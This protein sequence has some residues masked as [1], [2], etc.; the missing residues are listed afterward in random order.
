MDLVDAMNG[1]G[2]RTLEALKRRLEPVIA[3]MQK[4]L[5][6]VDVPR[7]P[8]ES[9]ERY[10]RRR[11][12]RFYVVAVAFHVCLV[13]PSI[14][15]IRGCN[16]HETPLGVPGGKGDKLTAGKPI[17]IQMQKKV[18]QRKRKVRKSPI[19]IYEMIQEEDLQTVAQT[20]AQFSD[21]AGVP[22]G[23]GSGACAAGSP[24][25]TVVGGT[26]Y[27]YR[28]KFGGPD[29]DA[30]SEG[31]KPLMNEVLKAGVVKKVAGYNNVVT[32]AELPKHSGQYFPAMLY[33]T[34]TGGISASDQEVSNLRD[35][36][37]NGGML[38][39]DVSGGSF[40]ENFTQFIRR[41][42]PNQKI[43]VIEFDNEIYRGA[44]MPYAL[45]HGCPIY[46]KHPG[47]GP[48]MGIWIGQRLSVFYS[49][50]DLGAGWAS[51]GIFQTRRRDVEQAYRMGI[52]II[53]YSLFYYKCTTS[54]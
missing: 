51:A 36:L 33:M 30:N 13:L 3:F 43:S 48:A 17:T 32:L 27:F 5:T 23:M 44:N 40:H 46:R 6:Y 45:L 21:V 18:V 42:L 8:G 31:V 19:S 54:S 26:L 50:G 11:M 52:N 15:S 29:W 37:M 14:I 28:V 2:G 49:R 7:L 38:F 53:T 35:Y 10:G 41:V 16:M 4:L 25:G 20:K 1:R 22:G 34:G 12:V 47:A 9:R 39:A 24:K